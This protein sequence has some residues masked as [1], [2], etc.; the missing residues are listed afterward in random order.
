M[1]HTIEHGPS[2][3]WLRARLAP[4]ETVCA[5]AGSMVARSPKL[6][7]TTRLNAG[8]GVG[9]G[10]KVLAVLTAIMRRLLGR[11]GLFVN[12]FSGPEGGEVILAPTLA[13]SIVRHVLDGRH[14]LLVQAG[15]YLAS[16]GDVTAKLRWGGLRTLFGGE[17]LFLLE[18]SGQGELFVNAY[19]GI[20]EIEVDGQYIAD[21]GHVV[22]FESTL[23]FRVRGLG[24]L[25]SLLF[26]GE[27][28]VCEFRG[29]GRLFIQSRNV[30]ALVGWITP[31]LRG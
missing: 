8:K 29:R 26:S 19:G 15:S 4:G 22:A 5:E 14:S 10:S 13:G 17:G 7:M 16:T 11:E 6:S 31:L 30:R 21:T 12:E 9:F 1:Q 24:G 23:D 3:A 25:K 28:L 2:F 27:G 18:C 20:V